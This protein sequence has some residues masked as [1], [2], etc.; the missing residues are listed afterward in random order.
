MP[1]AIQ[2]GN[3]GK[4]ICPCYFFENEY[5]HYI[6]LWYE[7]DYVA[8]KIQDTEDIEKSGW[9]LYRFSEPLNEDILISILK[10]VR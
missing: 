8:G 9:K 6:T 5:K 7:L 1:F 4:P 10:E 3:D 2:I